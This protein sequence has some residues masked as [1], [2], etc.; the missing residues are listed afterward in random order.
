M[1][2]ASFLFSGKGQVPVGSSTAVKG[3]RVQL[4]Q[5]EEYMTFYMLVCKF[6]VLHEGTGVR[7]VEYSGD[8]CTSTASIARGVQEFF[9]MFY[10]CFLFT[11]KGQV[12]AGSSTAVKGA[13]IPL[14]Q[15]EEY[16]TVSICLS[17]NFGFSMKVQA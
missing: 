13:Q 8:G 5:Q 3:A 15:K 7:C 10:A 12:P 14:G 4:R 2:S 6:W 16:M 11:G 1:F 17:V 9:P